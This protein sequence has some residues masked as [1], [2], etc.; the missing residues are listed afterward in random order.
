VGFWNVSSPSTRPIS[1]FGEV[2]MKPSQVG[3]REAH[4]S[5]SPL[6]RDEAAQG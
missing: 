5:A 3:I 2:Q 1:V 6:G 4:G